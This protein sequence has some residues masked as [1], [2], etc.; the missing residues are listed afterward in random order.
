MSDY[1][2]HPGEIEPTLTAIKEKYPN[3]KLMVGFQAHQHS[4]TRELIDG[5]TT[6]FDAVDTLVISDI[7]RSRDKD[8]DVQAMTTE[9]FVNRLRANYPSIIHGHSLD[10]T[11]T[12][13]QKLDEEYA[14]QAIIVLL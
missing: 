4:R 11:G 6:S 1:G 8:E 9:A 7:Y 2:H 5:F 12:I 13:L 3:K 10:T 14:N